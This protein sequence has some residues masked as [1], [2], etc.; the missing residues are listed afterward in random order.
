MELKFEFIA[1]AE[2]LLKQN[3]LL[4]EGEKVVLVTDRKK[5]PIFLALKKA[6]KKF[7]AKVR[8]LRLSPTREPSSPIPEAKGLFAWADVIIAPTN[9]SI[10]HSPETI[11]A[12][13]AGARCA[14]MPGITPELFVKAA[15][16]DLKKVMKVSNKLISR[17]SGAKFVDIVTP[18]GSHLKIDVRGLKFSTEAAP[19]TPSKRY[20]IPCGEVYCGPLK[21]ATGKIV[22]DVWDQKLPGGA[23]IYVQRGKITKWGRGADTFVNYLRNIGSCALRAVELGIGTNYA[24]LEPIR[25]VL[26]DEKIYGSTHIAFGSWGTERPCPVHTDV[27]MLKPTVWIDGRK[28]IERG[29]FLL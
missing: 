4:K 28:I 24:H 21:F 16:T 14:T 12:C 2:K 11:I 10:T 1:A 20:N 23:W 15:Q 8:T 27:I 19:L 7:G 22:I 3:I 13:D 18:S 26:H 25:N 9:K 5:C 29:K 17:L 6:C